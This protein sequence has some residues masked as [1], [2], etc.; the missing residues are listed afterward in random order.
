MANTRALASVSVEPQDPPASLIQEQFWVLHQLEPSSPAYNVPCVS[1]LEGELDPSVLEAALQSVIRR[2]AV[3]RATFYLDEEG[4][5]RQ[6]AGSWRPVPLPQEDLR[7]RMCNNGGEDL[8]EQAVKKEIARPFDLAAGPPLRFRL[9]RTGDRAYVLAITAHHI[10]FDLATKDLFAEQLGEEYRAALAGRQVSGCSEPPSYDAFSV[11]Q[12]RWLESPE[13]RHMEESWRRYLDGAEQQL[14]LPGSRRPEADEKRSGEIVP[15]R[16]D[17]ELRELV[18]AFCKKESVTPFLVLLLAW[19]LTLARSSG[20]TKCSLGVPF[21]NRRNAAFKQVLGCFVNILPLV[22]D[23][24][25]N[26]SLR[27]ALRD[28]RMAMLKL[29]RMQEMPFSHLVRILGDRASAGRNPFFQAGFTF[30][31]PM[32]LRLEGLRVTPRPV[33]N[34]GAQLDLFTTFWEEADAVVGHIEY[35]TALFPAAAVERIAGTLLTAVREICTNA[36]QTAHAVALSPDP[37]APLNART[38]HFPMPVPT[39]PE[40]E[41]LHAFW[42]RQLAGE[43]PQLDLPLDRKRQKEPAPVRAT[44]S[45]SMTAALTG[46]VRSLE[47]T[48]GVSRT[49]IL[50]TGFQT[51]LM[52]YTGQEDVLVGMPVS[53]PIAGSGADRACLVNTVILRTP[54]AGDSTF[55]EQLQR[56]T[57][58]LADAK[59]HAQ[60]PFP[61]LLKELGRGGLSGLPLMQ[62]MFSMTDGESA[63]EAAELPQ[64]GAGHPDLTLGIV[65]NEG[66]LTGTFGYSPDLFE[67]A[68]IGRMTGHYQVLLEVA[69]ADPR[70][71]LAE[72]PFLTPEER[73][74]LLFSRNDT[75]T[76]NPGPFCIHELFEA[77]A[78][79]APDAAALEFEGTVLTYAE[80]DARSSSF[81]EHLRS[82][83]VGRDMLVGLYME[84]SLEM[85][86]GLLGI[87]KAGAAYLPLDRLFPRARLEFMLGDAQPRLVATLARLRSDVPAC[88]CPIVCVDDFSAARA[89]RSGGARPTGNDLA[90]VL[91]TSGSTGRPKGVEVLHRGVVNFLHAMRKEPGID[92]GDTLLSVTTISFDILGLELWLP[93]TS[94]AKVVLLPAEVSMDG[95]RLAEAMDRT[96]ATVMQATP[97][98]WRLLLESGWKG[99]SGLKILCG[100]EAWPR[101]LASQL[102]SRCSSLWNMYGPTETTIWSAVDRVRHNEAVSIGRPIANTTFYVVDRQLQPVPQGVPGELLIGGDGLARGYLNRPE[103]TAERFIPDPLSGLEGRLY[104]TGDLVRSLPDGRLEFLGRLDHQVK[105]RGFRI[106]L[107]DIESA[108]CTAAG[109]KQAVA[110]VR[111][112]GGEKQLAAYLVPEPGAGLSAGRL[113]QHLR[114]ALPPYMMPNVF[115]TLERMPLTANGKIDRKALPPP[116]A[117]LTDRE[118]ACLVPRTEIERTVTA[119]WREVLQQEQIGMNDNFFDLGGH[120]LRMAR[121]RT[122]LHETLKRDLTMV[123]LFRYPTVGSLARYVSADR[124]EAAC[125]A[126][127]DERREKLN[128]GR[129]RLRQRFLK[130][131]QAGHPMSERSRQDE[132]R[133]P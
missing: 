97:A 57:R 129:S 98:T 91:Y 29:H 113:R 93:L 3:F 20:Q 4:T 51:L 37:A 43:L 103:L 17:G 14:R 83:G 25:A 104:R 34:G 87:L 109:V 47:E 36:E 12:K 50:L 131:E 123:E 127:G 45:F 95:K 133:N 67:E 58:T 62:A 52:R 100:G 108:L 6:K 90:Y 65:M 5:L 13:C 11:W 71:R 32:Q 119:I 61:L 38:A 120:S 18:S 89:E 44:R 56:T 106:E 33:H 121:V 9:F 39:G 63:E 81:A 23:I 72:L 7:S 114:E 130:R 107:A 112:E 115:V 10:V 69:L 125:V 80:L 49:E 70:K 94:G 28:V 99:N 26:P 22:F 102:L 59:A 54:V 68:T 64:A 66:A 105:I 41:R 74:D 8:L 79:R 15:V 124:S 122:R 101:E 2:H 27:G 111:E 117:V 126:T 88:T 84:P 30:E 128:E 31:H 19:A 73:H 55:E 16:L 35:D 118:T 85:V 86:V 24:S 77:Q 96:G 78:K 76:E 82:L 116:V 53:V 110:V 46:K 40:S 1:S 75:R 48:T 21:T 42:K 92:A 60:Y 132:L